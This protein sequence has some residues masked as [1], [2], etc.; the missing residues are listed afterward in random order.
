M[1]LRFQVLLLERWLDNLLSLGVVRSRKER[2]WWISNIFLFNDDFF[3]VSELLKMLMSFFFLNC[4]FFYNRLLLLFFLNPLFN[5]IVLQSLCNT[6]A[7]ITMLPL[8]FHYALLPYVWLR[9]SDIESLGQF[10]DHLVF[11]S[12]L[13]SIRR[14]GLVSMRLLPCVAFSRH[15]RR[16]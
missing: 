4:F 12:K 3:L 8:F 9:F 15:K 2:A 1:Q 13:E 7:Q 10:P 14:V 6:V 11:R 16:G 5:C